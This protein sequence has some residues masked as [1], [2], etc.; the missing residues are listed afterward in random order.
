MG[1]KGEVGEKGEPGLRGEPGPIGTKGVD[2]PVGPEGNMTN[3]YLI[4]KFLFIYRSFWPSRAW[5]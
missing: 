1:R 5:G 3:F 4:P 2:G